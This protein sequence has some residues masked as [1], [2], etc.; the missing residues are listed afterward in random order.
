M[1]LS[2]ARYMQ[3]SKLAAIENL[4]VQGEEELLALMGK[5]F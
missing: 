1:Q 4:V 3:L 2:R 5:T